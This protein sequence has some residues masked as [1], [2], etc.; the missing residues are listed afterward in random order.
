MNNQ[1]SLV[2]VVI[3]TH[4]MALYLPDAVESVRAQTYSPLEIIIIDDGSTDDTSK[5]VAQWDGDPRVRYIYQENQGQTRAKNRG[6]AEAGGKFIAFLDGDD[7]WR[8]TKLERQ[9]PLFD[10]N[11]RVGVVHSDE[12]F[13]D[14]QGREIGKRQVER[15]QGRITEQLLIDNFVEFG[16][17]VVRREALDKLGVF[18]ESL[19][20]SIDYDLWLRLS[21][22]YD[23]MCLDEPMLEY[24]IWGGQMSHKMLQRT[25]CILR[26]LD[27]FENEH[28]HVVGKSAL[29][30][31]KASTYVTRGF[32]RMSSGEG[33]I[34]AFR[35]MLHAIR[36]DPLNV[37]AIKGLVKILLGRKS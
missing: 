31:S 28:G 20:M 9:M 25:D 3:A 22:A 34:A 32:A 36:L 35:E 37:P 23:F 30:K 27:K 5:V 11:E 4:N 6:I 13:I 2:S 33:R 8:P 21:T 19:S 1:N 15:P 26:V 10:V 29:R 17:A 14:E 16:S 24:R 12:V 18:D 7:R